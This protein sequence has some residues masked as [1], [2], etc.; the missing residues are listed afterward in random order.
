M[1]DDE[2]YIL[3][4]T[5]LQPMESTLSHLLPL[6]LSDTPLQT[7]HRLE[8]KGQVFYCNSYTRTLKRNSYTISY[9]STESDENKAFGFI[10]YFT[11]VPACG[12]YL[13]VSILEP[14]RIASE[15][16]GLSAPST[17]HAA[18][19]LPVKESEELDLIHV[20]SIANKCVHVQVDEHHQFLVE[21]DIQVLLD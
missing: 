3:G 7:F 6:G 16:L 17:D 4:N 13:V 10:K 5:F 20:S 2:T 19:L 21:M 14:Y 9:W 15:A 11:I 8:Y 18:R 1:L 12:V